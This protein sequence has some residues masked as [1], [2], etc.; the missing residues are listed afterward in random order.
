MTRREKLIAKFKQN[1]KHVRFEQMESL[2]LSSGF[3]LRRVRGSHYYYKREN[4]LIAI[5]KPHAGRKFCAPQ[6]V[7]DILKYFEAE[8]GGEREYE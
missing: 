3:I 2:L 4:E 1:P 8:E 6:D 5:V 7:K